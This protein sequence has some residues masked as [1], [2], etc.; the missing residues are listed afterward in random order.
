MNPTGW[1]R[2]ASRKNQKRVN[3][4]TTEGFVLGC[5]IFMA[6]GA[7]FP[8]NSAAPTNPLVAHEIPDAQFKVPVF[9]FPPP[10]YSP[11]GFELADLRSLP[12][13]DCHDCTV[14]VRDYTGEILRRFF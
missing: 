10:S 2:P 3:V 13:V 7:R 14:R 5:R 6:S 8:L 9:C 1:A 4:F 11:Q 12:L